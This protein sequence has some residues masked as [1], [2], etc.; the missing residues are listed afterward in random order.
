MSGVINIISTA[1]KD[2]FSTKVYAKTEQIMP[3]YYDYGY[4]DYQASIHIPATQ[5]IRSFFSF[6]LMHTDDWDPRLYILPH[7]QRD[8][9]S[10]Y[11]KLLMS[12]SGKFNVAISG[13]QARSQFDRYHSNWKFYLEHYR[14]DMRKSNLQILKM[15]YL[16]DSRYLLSFAVSRLFSQK[17]FGVREL[18][19]KG[20]FSNFIFK[21][22]ETLRWP[23]SGLRNP[24]GASHSLVI[25]QGDY[26]EYKEQKTHIIRTNISGN[27][28]IHKHHEVKWGGEYTYQTLSN[29][30][31][32]V[33]DSLS[34]LVDQYRYHPKEISGYLQD[35]ID[36]RGLYVKLGCRYDY[37][38]WDIDSVRY[39]SVIS[40][41]IGASFMVTDKL[42]FRTNIGRYVQPPLYDYIYGYHSLLPIPQHLTDI[43]PIG[44][45]TLQPE[46]TISY[47]I[48]LQGELTKT[49][50][51]T[52]NSYYKTVTDLVGTRLDSIGT[53][54]YVSFFN[55]EYALMRGY[56]IVMNFSKPH[57]DGKISYTLSWAQGLSSYALEVY[58][59]RYIDPE[60]KPPKR[61]YNLDFDQRHKFLIQG[62]IKLPLGANA[63]IFGHFGDGFPY[64][65]PGPEGK[66]EERNITRLP[67]QRQVDCVLSKTLKI[68]IFSVNANLE[69]INLLN[70]RYE[71]NP[72]F[73]LVPLETIEKEDFDHPPPY[74][75]LR[76]SY[77]AP[78]ADLNHDG[79]LTPFEE[80]EAYRELIKATDDWVNAYTAPRRARLGVSV[81]F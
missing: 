37:Y 20:P 45:P 58:D 16:P 48:G 54:V 75:D 11:G 1:P 3:F 28:Q 36:Y 15:N 39:I 35:N 18:D 71:V 6:D 13:A 43:P 72:H 74:T 70:V 47:E 49:I 29:F 55:V 79:M 2:R 66:F 12:P 73:P 56:E 53:Q 61:E 19:I 32:F 25:C 31:C 65:P 63:Y 33:G 78:S 21:D 62:V 46:K 14:S 8:D 30:G 51:L 59:R 60:Y 24:F 44:N 42:L 7:K 69:V 64:T 76:S 26:P 67:F 57:F 50:G 38:D 10:I 52:V 4:Q 40:P 23:R 9:Y 80:Y 68:G 22:Y 34:R 41:R 77:Y 27:M 17:L 5:K 81:A